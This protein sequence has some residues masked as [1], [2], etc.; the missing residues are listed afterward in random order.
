MSTPA[1]W[2]RRIWYLLN[3]GRFDAALQEEMDAH[4]A[5]L[6]EPARFGNRLRLREESRDVWGWARLDA[7]VRDLR[8]AARGLRRTPIFTLV[9]IVS[10]AVG[11][12]LTTA[13]VSV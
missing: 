2:F 12:A 6:G 4:R 1:E 3:R 9:V 5:M 11:L 10:L 13:M 8:F 7:A